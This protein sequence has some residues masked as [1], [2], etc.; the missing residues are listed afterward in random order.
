M[1]Y[2]RLKYWHGCVRQ[3]GRQAVAEGVQTFRNGIRNFLR[4]GW[5]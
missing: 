1:T 2:L 3:L 5:S 4:I